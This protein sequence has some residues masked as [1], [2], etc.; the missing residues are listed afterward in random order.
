MAIDAG[1]HIRMTARMPDLLTGTRIAI[2]QLRMRWTLAENLASI[3]DAIAFAAARRARFCVFPELAVTGFHRRI[4][5]AAQPPGVAASLA[6]IASACRANALAVAVGAPTFDDDGRIRN[7][8]ILVNERG[9][10]AGVVDKIGLTA[11]EATF[12]APGTTRGSGELQGVRCTSVICREVEDLADVVP[13]VRS[14]GA[15]LVFW[16]GAMRPDPE[17][18]PADPPEHVVRA[19][20]LARMTGAHV[21]QANWPESL[22]YPEQSADCGESAVI[23]PTGAL[24]LRLPRAQPGVAIVTLGSADCEWRPEVE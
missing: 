4:A 18:P 14:G 17:K 9:E 23:D 16:P 21:V 8:H 15:Q 3:L 2:G 6:A 24:V 1:R 10:R 19:Q 12:F 20:E 5:E 13:Q 11:P 7:S 22:N